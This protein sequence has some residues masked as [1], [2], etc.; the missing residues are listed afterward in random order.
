MKLASIE[1][2]FTE[3][4]QNYFLAAAFF[5]KILKEEKIAD[6]PLNFDFSE[7][8]LLFNISIT[9]SQG[10]LMIL[11]HEKTEYF[12]TNLLLISRHCVFTANSF[13]ESY[14]MS[15]F[16]H[17][18]EFSG[19]FICVDSKN[20]MLFSSRTLYA[21][22]DYYAALHYSKG[23]ENIGMAIRYIRNAIVKLYKVVELLPALSLSFKKYYENTKALYEKLLI[24]YEK[25]TNI[26]VPED[27]PLILPA[28]YTKFPKI[29]ELLLRRNRE[30][31]ELHF[32]TQT[33]IRKIEDE[34][35]RKKKEIISVFEENEKK[36]LNEEQEF[37]AHYHLPEILYDY[38]Q[39]NETEHFLPEELRNR[40]LKFQNKGGLA[41]LLSN[42]ESAK[43]AYATC[44]DFKES[45]N[46][47]IS[48]EAADDA[49]QRACYGPTKY[50]LEKSEKMNHK[51]CSE[52]AKLF[53]IC[54]QAYSSLDNI[55]KSAVDSKGE[56]REM[57][58]K[59]D[60]DM[61]I[62]QESIPKTLIIRP[63][64]SKGLSQ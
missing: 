52:N 17:S 28:G 42:L 49:K 58:T 48:D 45:L 41:K 63:I 47:I 12:S 30:A 4:G 20:K 31:S 34:F 59:I 60:R 14:N 39:P 56:L 23:N 29:E 51:Y 24:E 19:K 37:L 50:T 26:K 36:Y 33:N 2:K 3:A 46:K 61:K 64:I 43:Q 8:N 40:I 27:V 9:K 35:M 25:N 18:K 22:C 15:N 62:I 11:E 13:E 55:R 10:Q 44:E 7:D 32:L 5:E 21:S 57:S 16:D 53:A 6:I 1:R 54:K 38:Y